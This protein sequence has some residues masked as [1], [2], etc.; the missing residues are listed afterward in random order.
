MDKLN[1]IAQMI[2]SYTEQIERYESLSTWCAL[3]TIICILAVLIFTSSLIVKNNGR[4]DCGKEK[5]YLILSGLFLTIPSIT[6]L[7][8]YTFAMNMRKVALFR[9]YLSFLESQ[10]NAMADSKMMLFDLQII[11]QFFSPQTFLV[12]GLGPVVMTLFLVLS[13]VLGFGLS[14]YFT[15]KLQNSTSKKG[16]KLLICVLGFVCI[17]FNG[18]C[19]YYLTTNASVA[20]TVFEN[21]QAGLSLK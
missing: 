1:D 21:C 10:W 17:L 16:M 13:A 14:F 6:T 4:S 5:Y 9:G 2:N 18:I 3:L 15:C 19:C 12:N 11:D 20:K 7:Y 8:L